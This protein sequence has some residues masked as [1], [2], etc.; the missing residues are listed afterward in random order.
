MAINNPN[1]LSSSEE[2]KGKNLWQKF[3]W[4]VWEFVKVASGEPSFFSK[5]RL[6]SG[7]AFM[8]FYFAEIIWLTYKSHFATERLTNSEFIANMVIVLLVAGYNVKKIQEEKSEK[9]NNE[10]S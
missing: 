3:K 5:K 4:L 8:L 6:E 7:L 1:K 2:L 9:L 10:K